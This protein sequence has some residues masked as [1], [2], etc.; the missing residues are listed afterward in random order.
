LFLDEIGDVPLE[1]QSKLLRALQEREI[2]RLGSPRTIRVDFRLIAATNRDLDDMVVKREFRSDLY[3]RLNVFPI[4]IPPLRERRED[5]PVLVRYFTQRFAK[6][7]RRP[8]ESIARDSMEMLCRWPW[9]GNVREPQNVIERAVIRSQ[10]TPPIVPPS[11]LLPLGLAQPVQVDDDI[12]H[13][14]IVDRALGA[15]APGVEGAGVIRIETDQI[16]GRKVKV[17]ALRILDPTAEDQ[18]QFAHVR[19]LEKRMAPPVVG[20]AMRSKR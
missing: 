18:M 16:D 11:A 2:E 4:R 15:A 14:G 20:S 5:I 9:P 17:E 19:T 6:R 3:Y 7:M 13:L 12:F 8:I 10:G 1:L